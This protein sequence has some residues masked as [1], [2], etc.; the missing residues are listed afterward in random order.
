MLHAVGSGSPLSFVALENTGL[1]RC[2]ELMHRFHA[3]PCAAGGLIHAN[4]SDGMS[5]IVSSDNWAL[6]KDNAVLVASA[7]SLPG[8][9]APML[10]RRETAQKL[11]ECQ[12]H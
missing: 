5:S 1:T 4:V 9:A 7:G 6:T 12:L 8:L 10:T 11:N 3:Q 2:S